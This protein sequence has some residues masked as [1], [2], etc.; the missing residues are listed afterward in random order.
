MNNYQQ[1]NNQMS[2]Q[3]PQQWS[4]FMP[5]K[6]QQTNFADRLNWLKK[7][8]LVFLIL[9]LLVLAGGV[10]LYQKSYQ[11][12]IEKQQQKQQAQI[13]PGPDSF[14]FEKNGIFIEA[15]Y[16][17]ITASGVEPALA[18]FGIGEPIIFRNDTNNEQRVELLNE[19]DVVF[20]D[21]LSPGA[22][23]DLSFHYPC[24]LYYY[25]NGQTQGKINIKE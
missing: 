9:C 24:E 7:H 4:S 19:Q 14:T 22:K 23:M 11:A 18:S 12:L 6:T 16:I 13:K 25:I 5:G 3:S 10:W 2:G 17:K 20:A 21:E 15:P 8:S 1:I